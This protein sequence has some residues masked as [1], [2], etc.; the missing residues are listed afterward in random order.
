VH[1]S[2]SGDEDVNDYFDGIASASSL[3]FGYSASHSESLAREYYEKFTDPVFCNSIGFRVQDD[4]FFFHE[5]GFEMVLSIHYYLVLKGDP[6]R[7]A[8]L[9]WRK[10]FV[11]SY[12]RG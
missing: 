8:Y 9:R 4:E 6:S 10:E 11:N 1:P 7:E 2:I 3:Q 12:R 5:G